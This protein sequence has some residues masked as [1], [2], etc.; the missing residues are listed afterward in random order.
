MAVFGICLGTFVFMLVGAFIGGFLKAKEAGVLP[1]LVAGIWAAW[2]FIH[3]AKVARYN[4]LH[5]V[6][7]EY[8]IAAK[9][10]FTRVRN[11]LAEVSYS[12]GDKWRIATA[13][14]HTGRMIA[15]LRFTDEE[16]H[17]DFD[18]RGHVHT[19]KERVQR[20]IA[21]EAL[22]RDTGNGTTMVQLDFLPKVEGA[23]FSACDPIIAQVLNTVDAAL[24][25][26]SLAGDPADTPLPAPPWWLLGL[27]AVTAL[28]MAGDV[29]K[30]VFQ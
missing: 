4:F 30:A 5:P 29:F 9:V 17:F 15:H 23:M 20:F 18:A 6:P 27:S 8:K 7:R 21:L 19:R 22:I 28:A 10:A 12:Y 11:L 2:P 26:G 13:D 1:G 25:H 14:T 16:T 3:H 24:G